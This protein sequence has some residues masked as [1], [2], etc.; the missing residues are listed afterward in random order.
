MF[1]ERSLNLKGKFLECSGNQKLTFWER[2]QNLNLFAG[3]GH[4]GG[5]MNGC[6]ANKW[7]CKSHDNDKVDVIHPDYIQF[8]KYF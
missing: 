4:G 1:L 5:A 2:S 3:W 6:E 7:S 8:R